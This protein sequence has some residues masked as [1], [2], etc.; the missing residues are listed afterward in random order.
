MRLH[1]YY[2]RTHFTRTYLFRLEVSPRPETA[3][4]HEMFV[5]EVSI[6]SSLVF[7]V[8]ILVILCV[9][10]T[11]SITRQRHAADKLRCEQQQAEMNG[12]GLCSVCFVFILYTDSISD[13]SPLLEKRETLSRDCELGETPRWASQ[14]Y[15]PHPL[16]LLPPPASLTSQSRL[17]SSSSLIQRP[18]L[19]AINKNFTSPS[20][21]SLDPS[22]ADSCTD[23]TLNIREVVSPV[24][25]LMTA[26]T[27]T[28]E[29]MPAPLSGRRESKPEVLEVSSPSLCPPPRPPRHSKSLGHIPKLLEERTQEPGVRARRRR[30]ASVCKSTHSL[31]ECSE[32]CFSAG[33]GGAG[34]QLVTITTGPM[35]L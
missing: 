16:A 13:C 33:E 6:L 31:F 11:C 10:L 27:Q 34:G 14:R 21:R 12:Y 35:V 26:Q 23:L 25:P 29:R 19:T 3:K 17:L 20:L 28:E 4:R 18:L 9:L 1:D 8:S 5:R 24:K 22:S 30:S 7:G 2:F 32:G 15:A